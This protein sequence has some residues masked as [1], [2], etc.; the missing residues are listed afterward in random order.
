MGETGIAAGFFG[1]SMMTTEGIYRVES[2]KGK[3]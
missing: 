1:R 3:R 2:H